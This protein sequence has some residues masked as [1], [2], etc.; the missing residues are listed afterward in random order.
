MFSVCAV[1]EGEVADI[2]SVATSTI[3]L[4]KRA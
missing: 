1:A 4:P 3:A 2:A